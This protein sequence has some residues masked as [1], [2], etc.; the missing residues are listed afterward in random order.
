MNI[1]IKLNEEE[2][3][4]LIRALSCLQMNIPF[5]HQEEYEKAI[6]LQSKIAEALDYI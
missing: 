2:V 4:M 3:S 6:N 5:T 1:S